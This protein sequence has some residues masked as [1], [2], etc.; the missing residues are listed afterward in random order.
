MHY[1]ST[2]ALG[3]LPVFY[4]GEFYQTIPVIFHFLFVYPFLLNPITTIIFIP[5]FCYV[6]YQSIKHKNATFMILATFF[7][8]ILVSQAFFFVKWTRYM[9]PTLPFMYLITA[10]ALAAFQQYKR[11]QFNHAMLIVCLILINSVFALSYFITAFTKPDTRVAASYFARQTIAPHAPLLSEIYDMG[12][13]PF[14]D[15][16]TDISLF[17]FYDL[18]NNSPTITTDAL[19]RTLA[20]RDYIIVPSQ[21]ILKTRLFHKEKFP[22]GNAY[23]HALLDGRLGYTKIYE[24]PC[25]IFC[26]ITYLGN[27]VFRFEQ[28]AN[29]FD[30]PTVMIF[31]KI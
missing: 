18:D 30:R 2:L 24:T 7:L 6:I 4:T 23:Y 15:N 27:P 11:K 13:V 17:H 22:K 14:N 12:I 28:T 1:E 21:R 29:V 9:V 3:T 10:I 25:D 31:K 26:K 8:L 16:F 20:G 19:Q 5:A